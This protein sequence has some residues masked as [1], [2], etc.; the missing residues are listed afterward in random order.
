MK[1][2]RIL[3]DT[4]VLIDYLMKREPFKC[5]AESILNACTSDEMK[6]CIAA[7]SISN[8]F[9][10]LRKTFSV[11][12]RRDILSVL[13]QIL[14]VAGIDEDMIVRALQNVDFT[15]FEDCLQME[16]AREFKAQFIITRNLEDFQHSPIP[17]ISPDKFIENYMQDLFLAFG[18]D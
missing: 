12:E 1:N 3:L 5:S 13:C 14:T 4:N 10:I 15:D 11:E 9:F 18:E 7:H 2:M 16:C 8:L 17:A 6:G